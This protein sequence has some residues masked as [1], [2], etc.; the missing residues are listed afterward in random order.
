MPKPS[1]PPAAAG[2]RAA[3]PAAAWAGVAAGRSE[4]LG[5]LFGAC[6]PRRGAGRGARLPLQR[7]IEPARHGARLMSSRSLITVLVALVFAVSPLAALAAE[8]QITDI[9]Q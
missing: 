2:S 5:G 1:A 4:P 9:K 8:K 6:R 7:G 3:R